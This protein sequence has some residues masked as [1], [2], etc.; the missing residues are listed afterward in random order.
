ME[1]EQ[2][3][4]QDNMSHSC[5]IYPATA[6]ETPESSN[7][8]GYPMM[9]MYSMA[10]GSGVNS[11]LA[12]NQMEKLTLGQE[13]VEQNEVSKLACTIPAVPDHKASSSVSDISSNT[14]SIVDPPTLSLGLSL[15]SD[16]RQ[17]SPRHTPLH[18]V[19]CF[20]NE[21]SIITVA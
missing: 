1:E 13:N 21:D 4:H 19:P 2:I 5:P 14:S 8:N 17:K 6:T 7:R 15:S 12:R 11:V 10:V 18:A 20:N 9:P 3:Q 16:Q